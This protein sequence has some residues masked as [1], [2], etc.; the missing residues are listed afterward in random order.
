MA[1]NGKNF[2]LISP[3]SADNKKCAEAFAENAGVMKSQRQH[4]ELDD[5]EAMSG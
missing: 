5:R 3:D 2:N 4:D 1:G